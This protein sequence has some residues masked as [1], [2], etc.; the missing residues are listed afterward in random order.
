MA[1]A[2]QQV[3]H[4]NDAGDA[5][6]SAKITVD[7]EGFLSK[8]SENLHP[9]KLDHSFTLTFHRHVAQRLAQPVFQIDREP[10]AL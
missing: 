5:T 6:Q 4:A 2:E 7:K 9:E 1:D 10:I 8:Q 3:S